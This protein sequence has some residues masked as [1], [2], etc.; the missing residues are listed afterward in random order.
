M[1]FSFG[2]AGGEKKT[3]TLF[4]NTTAPAGGLFGGS[5]QQPQQSNAAAPSL[6]GTSTAA[7]ATGGL[8][9]STTQ[10][11]PQQNAGTSL[12]GGALGQ[13]QQQQQQPQ[14]QTSSL[15][16]QMGQ[17]QQPQQPQQQQQ[18]QQPQSH[19]QQFSNSLFGSSLQPAPG[20]NPVQAQSLQQTREGLPQ[21]RQSTAQ[22]YA[23]ASIN[24]HRMSIDWSLVS[25]LIQNR[26]EVCHT[27]NPGA[28][29][30]MGS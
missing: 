2:N 21:L 7:P 20:L 6:F 4:G 28:E 14:A 18:Q 29:Q 13:T 24:G 12:F 10:Q 19:Q 17:A 11:P 5:L 30:Q 23:G 8:F 22:P 25:K 27:T 1:S 3:G 15:W 9:G 26:R 16:G